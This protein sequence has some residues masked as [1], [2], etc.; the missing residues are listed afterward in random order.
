[1]TAGDT[2]SRYRIT[3]RIGQGGM[4]VVYKA[5]DTR[6][7]R[8]VALKFLPP[9]SLD[10]EDRKRLVNE[11]QSAALIR[12]P[13]VCPIYDVEDVDGQTFIAMAWLE[14]ETLAHRIGRGPL[15]ITAAIDFAI[16]IAKGLE[17]AHALGVIHR[18]VK[19]SNILV[20]ADGHVSI[21]DFGLALRAG[22]TRITEVGKA[23]GTPA[24]MSP[25]QVCGRAIDRRTDLWSLGVLLFEMVTASLPFRRDHQAAVTHAIAFDEAPAVTSLRPDAPPEL[26]SI[27]ETAMAKRPEDRWQ[28]AREM[29]A[30]L[31]RL[32]GGLAS[33]GLAPSFIATRTMIGPI[34]RKWRTWHVAT[35]AAVLC[36]AGVGGYEYYRSHTLSRSAAATA[37]PGKQIVVLPFQLA[38]EEAGARSISDGLLEVLTEELSG[39][40]GSQGIA[41]PVPASEVL[42]R[43]ISSVAEAR[44]FF[45]VDL[46]VTGSAEPRGNTLHCTLRLVDAVNGR[47]IASTEFDYDPASPREAKNRAIAQMNSM[48]GVR[49]NPA[50]ALQGTSSDSAAP[51]A[52][53]PYLE[54]R[55]F[56][57]RYD[58]HGNLEKAAASFQRAVDLD[59]NYA[60]AWAGIG[61]TYWREARGNSDAGSRCA[62][63]TERRASRE[64]RSRPR[65]RAFSS[66]FDLR[67]GRQERGR[68][69]PTT[70]GDQP[71]A[72]QCRGSARTG[73]RLP[74]AGTLF[75]GG[76][77]VSG[78]HACPSHGLVRPFASRPVLPG[79][80]TLQGSGSLVPPRHGTR[81]RQ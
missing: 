44:R 38:A 4:G 5:E 78:G 51:G 36:F 55:G 74:I 63:C 27:I 61:E 29:A 72:G 26:R 64:A 14:G 60:L 49:S 15:A 13:N 3:G 11:A 45:G 30:A 18:D 28:T 66:G 1:M 32:Q 19:S 25:E 57:A 31:H 20:S 52:Y 33:Q 7:N 79:P 24:Y 59:P 47:Q 58:V 76:S 23:A 21:L 53:S 10:E 12:H 46:A 54:G 80:R 35:A 81:T 50:T 40:D 48:L 69:R 70:P 56:L 77:A 9:D 67:H 37:D 39:F 2:I 73:S 17:A 68:H 8:P 65:H 75:R 22:A 42:R 34:R 62:R 6:L 41:A 16:Q 71:C 43:G